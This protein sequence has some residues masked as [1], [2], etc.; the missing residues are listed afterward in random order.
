MRQW[1]LV[2]ITG[3]PFL[4]RFLVLDRSLDV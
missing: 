4:L 3:E 2:W 1:R